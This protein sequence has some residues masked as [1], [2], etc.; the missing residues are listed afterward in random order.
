MEE[1]VTFWE[2]SSSPPVACVGRFLVISCEKEFSETH[3]GGCDIIESFIS[4]ELNP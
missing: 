2:K 1:E 4:V 3:M